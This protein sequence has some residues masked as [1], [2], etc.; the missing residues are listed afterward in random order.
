[1]QLHGAQTLR[2]VARPVQTSGRVRIGSRSGR[3]PFITACT[4]PVPSVGSGQPVPPC[5][6]CRVGFFG[7]GSGFSGWVGFWVKKHGL[8]PAH[9]LLRVKNYGSYP[10]VALVGSGRVFFGR[11]GLVRWPM[12][13]SSGGNSF[14]SEGR[15]EGIGNTRLELAIT[16]EIILRLELAQESRTLTAQKFEL[17]RR[18]KTRGTGL[19]VI[20]KSRM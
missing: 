13:R 10:P 14:P 2:V 19:A 12:S 16:K 6:T 9:E 8:Y 4:R 15:S 20:E 7:F 5:L 1:V 11:V 3:G 18:F 17:K